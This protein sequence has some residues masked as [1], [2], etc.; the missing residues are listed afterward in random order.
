[1]TREFAPGF[2]VSGVAHLLHAFHPGV[3]RDLGLKLA[4]LARPIGTTAL[5]PDGRRIDITSDAGATAA[6][7]ARISPADGAAYAPVMARLTRLAGALGGYLNQTPPSPLPS[8]NSLRANLSLGLFALELRRLGKKDFLELTRILTMNVA[9]LGQDFFESDLVKGLLAF[10]ATLGLFLGPRSP[11]TVFNLLYRL[12]GFGKHGMGGLH[13][14]M[15]GMGALTEAL[16][17]GGNARRCDDPHQCPRRAHPDR[18]GDR[19]RRGARRRRGDPRARRRLQRRSAA[20]PAEAAG[21]GLLDVNSP[22]ASA[23]CG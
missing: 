2:K 4:S 14:P 21:P 22:S 12:A 15:G 13:L 5:A 10:D 16:A 8:A 7:I 23:I 20:H 19:G 11:N 6:S 3:G 9:D 17:A 18:E 1:M